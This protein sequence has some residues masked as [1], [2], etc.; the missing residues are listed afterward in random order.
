MTL[1]LLIGRHV[2]ASAALAALLAVLNPGFAAAADAKVAVAAN[3]TEPA[4][5]I[6]RLF[7]AASGHKVLFSFG[8]TG[9][10]YAQITQGAPF[11][12][13][14]AAD[15]ATPAK[16]IVNGHAV[17]GTVFTYAIGKLVLF[18]R[19]KDLVRGE[20][21]LSDAK[22]TR[23][24]IANPATA[25]YGA[26]AVEVMNALGVNQA[27]AP[28]IVQGNTIAQTFQFVETGNAEVGFVALSQIALATGGSRWVVP[29]HLHRP[30]AQDAVLLKPGAEN[31]AAKAFLAF[32]RSP[33][34]R[35]II[36]KFGYGVGD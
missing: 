4:R 28:K 5:Q 16:T 9:Q 19:T 23:I 22:F 7:E 24:A 8:A 33:E 13:F 32:L 34:A 27:L 3:F 30:I 6:G 35:K 2:L 11:D 20:A 10:F 14:V 36:E 31:A 1:R 26:A 17:P 12:V 29:A 15:Q 21:T 18:S 25:P